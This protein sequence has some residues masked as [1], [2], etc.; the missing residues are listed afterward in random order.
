M[1]QSPKGAVIWEFG[2]FGYTK[3][4]WSAMGCRSVGMLIIPC[5]RKP[6][7]KTFLCAVIKVFNFCF[8]IL[9]S[10]FFVSVKVLIPRVLEVKTFIS[11]LF[12]QQL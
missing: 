11:V 7:A 12:I 9:L 3:P 1:R 5:L 10:L 2:L 8:F 6:I 4:K